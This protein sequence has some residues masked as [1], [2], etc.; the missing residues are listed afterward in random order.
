MF[1]IDYRH[2]EQHRTCVQETFCPCSA[3]RVASIAATQVQKQPSTMCIQGRPCKRPS[4]FSHGRARKWKKG[5][6]AREARD[7]QP[8]LRPRQDHPR[9]FAFGLT[10]NIS[11][12]E[13]NLSL[14]GATLTKPR[15]SQRDLFF[16]QPPGSAPRR[17]RPRR[18]AHSCQ[19]ERDDAYPRMLRR[20]LPS[21]KS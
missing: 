17:N 18:N 14:A 16:R 10:R 20:R 1:P 6:R 2:L 8:G 15:H 7:R 5:G 9:L 12:R 4:S 13:M 11:A 19:I 21:H 3:M